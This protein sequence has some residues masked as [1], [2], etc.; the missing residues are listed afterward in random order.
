MSAAMTFHIRERRADGQLV[1]IFIDDRRDPL[2]IDDDG[3][4]GDEPR[5]AEHPP[6]GQGLDDHRVSVTLARCGGRSGS[7]PRATDSALA[8]R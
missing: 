3:A 1:G 8:A 5:L 4:A 7:S 2:A 6:V